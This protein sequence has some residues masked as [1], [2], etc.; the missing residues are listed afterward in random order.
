MKVMDVKRESRRVS[1]SGLFFGL[2]N[3]DTVR[4]CLLRLWGGVGVLHMWGENIG[5]RLRVRKIL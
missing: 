5:R 4:R 2:R 1:A 3:T